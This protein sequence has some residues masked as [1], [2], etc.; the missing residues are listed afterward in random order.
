[1]DYGTKEPKMYQQCHILTKLM[2]HRKYYVCRYNTW[3]PQMFCISDIVQAQLSFAVIPI[4]GGR[5][6][7][8]SI[9]RSLALLDGSFSVVC[10]L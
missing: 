2:T 10:N 4:K 5:R 7:M 1:M 8:L 9:L 6:K 3:E